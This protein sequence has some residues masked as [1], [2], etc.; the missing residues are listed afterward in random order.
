MKHIYLFVILISLSVTM[1]SQ[2]NDLDFRKA[3]DFLYD[4]NI[5]IHAAEKNIELSKRETQFI[6]AS[7]LPVV[8]MTGTYSI[9][10]NKIS[11]CQEYASILEPI[12]DKYSGTFLVSDVLDYLSNQLGD[13]SFDVPIFEDDFA[14]VDL[15][16]IYPIFTAGKR[17]EAH[18]IS[19]NNE[20]M[21][22]YEK[23]SIMA[24]KYLE[25][26]DIY[27]SLSLAE[28]ILDVLKETHDITEKHYSQ[29]LKLEKTGMFDK[30]ET[31]LVKV[32]LDE[33]DRNLKKAK[34]QAEVLRLALFKIIGLD[35]IPDKNSWTLSTPLF[36]NEKYP[37]KVWFKDM[38]K[39]NAF[40]YK[41]SEIHQ[42]ISESALAI[43]RSNYFPIVSVFGKQTLL[44]Y[45]VPD[46]L[47]PRSVAGVNLSWDIFD[48]LARERSIQKI[49]IETQI[50][51]DIQQNLKNDLDIAVDEWYSNLEQS[52]IDAQDLKSSLD[53]AREIL[54]IK[55]KSFTEGLVTSQQ[56]LDAIAL[57]NK[58][59]LLLLTTHYEYDIALANLCCLCGIPEYFESYISN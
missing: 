1:Q 34:N 54:R 6:N 26:A 37:A 57:V 29:A 49:K 32:A 33:S 25:L 43:A 51:D 41:Q 28:S 38:L 10:S 23:E 30:A 24:G 40:I 12:K 17:M 45:Q 18:K 14:S 22:E 44:S 46:N 36:I 3:A 48:G 50:T 55:K 20:K 9:M 35:S 39:E 21:S 8:T 59:H 15:E 42:E 16:L 11:V 7:W 58:T 53:F 47:I 27:F 5:S 2:S 52:C 13:L 56:V 4:N 31:L 19:K